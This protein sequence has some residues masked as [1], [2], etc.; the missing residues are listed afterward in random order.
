M[1]G[2]YN[3]MQRGGHGQY[4]NNRSNFQGPNRGG[5]HQHEMMTQQQYMMNRNN[6]VNMATPGVPQN[7]APP[8]QMIN[9]N[10]M[11]QQHLNQSMAQ[12]SVGGSSSV[13]SSS[14]P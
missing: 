1:G 12:M 11:N 8:P 10:M 9:Q 14:A 13:A 7:M 4:V 2:G 5:Y 6:S 3:T